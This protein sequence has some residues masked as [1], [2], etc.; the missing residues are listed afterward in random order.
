M[1]TQIETSA[2][3][4]KWVCKD[5]H[6]CVLNPK[7]AFMRGNILRCTKVGSGFECRLKSWLGKNQN[8][9]NFWAISL[10]SFPFCCHLVPYF[11]LIFSQTCQ[12]LQWGWGTVTLDYYHC[13]DT[14]Y[15]NLTRK[16]RAQILKKE[17]M[18]FQKCPS[19]CVRSKWLGD[20]IDFLVFVWFS[21]KIFWWGWA[22]LYH[23]RFLS[24]L[25]YIL[26]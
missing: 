10:E 2:Q 18:T 12:I 8:R 9:A 21:A 16:D 20:K 22:R 4:S 23:S 3:A 15:H 14:S 11:H 17:R 5:K 26:N 13:F 1:T 6:I 7:E 24:V 19:V 25:W